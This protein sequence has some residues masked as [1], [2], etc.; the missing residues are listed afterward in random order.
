MAM[1]T[2]GEELHVLE[3]TNMPDR[4]LISLFPRKHNHR[5]KNNA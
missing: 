2:L 3:I 5:M 4:N 1:L